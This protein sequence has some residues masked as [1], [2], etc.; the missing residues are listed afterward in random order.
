MKCSFYQPCAAGALLSP[1]MCPQSR[2]I[3]LSEVGCYSTTSSGFRRKITKKTTFDGPTKL[4]ISRKEDIADKVDSF[5]NETSQIPST[6]NDNK[7]IMTDI[8]SSDDSFSSLNPSAPVLKNEWITIFLLNFVAVIWGTQHS[9]IKLVLSDEDIS[10]AGFTLARFSLALLTVLPFTPNI[11]DFFNDLPY[12]DNNEPTSILEKT[13]PTTT[14]QENKSLENDEVPGA[15]SSS[16]NA[17]AWRWGLEMGLWMFLGYAFQAVG[18]L[19]CIISLLSIFL[20]KFIL[21]S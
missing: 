1:S 3:S 18:L 9:V 10:S 6:Y 11:Q 14:T 2:M 17:L 12:N 7:K 13:K 16:D 19:V 21:I 15:I 4:F 5:Q 8:A 20:L